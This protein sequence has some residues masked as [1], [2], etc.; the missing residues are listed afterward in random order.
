MSSDRFGHCTP[1]VAELSVSSDPFGHCTP[2]VIEL[3]V[4]S[5]LFGTQRGVRAF[6]CAG[7]SSGGNTFPLL[8][9]IIKLPDNQR[10]RGVEYMF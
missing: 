5:D 9:F 1:K 4:S 8:C 6:E 10:F 3:S 2:K 7:M